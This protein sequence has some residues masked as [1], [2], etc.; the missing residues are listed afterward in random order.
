[1]IAELASHAASLSPPFTHR[2]I[3]NRTGGLP[4]PEPSSAQAVAL[5]SAR[6]GVDADGAQPFVSSA[7]LA[8]RTSTLAHLLAASSSRRSRTLDASSSALRR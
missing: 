2:V 3:G 8:M 6:S 1:M 7:V 5:M 4:E